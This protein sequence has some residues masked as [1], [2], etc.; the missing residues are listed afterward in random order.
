MNPD[1]N[2]FI[3]GAN[4]F[5]GAYIIKALL[6]RGYKHIAALRRPN[7]RMGLVVDIQ[8]Q[9]R[10]VEGDLFDY[11]LLQ[12]ELRSANTVIHSAAMISFV[13]RDLKQ[14]LKVSCPKSL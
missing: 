9:V 11:E 1:S 6:S 3:T 7:G 8:D 12:R 14:M 4:G 5:V 10:W 13:G 2:I